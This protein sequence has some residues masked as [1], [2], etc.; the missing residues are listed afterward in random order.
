MGVDS[1]ICSRF[2]AESALSVSGFKFLNE[3]KFAIFTG[4]HLK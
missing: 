3:L 2:V 1:T 4:N